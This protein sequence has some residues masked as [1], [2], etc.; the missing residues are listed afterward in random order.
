MIKTKHLAHN[1]LK[2][3]SS[4]T[5]EGF[6]KLDRIDITFNEVKNFSITSS[7]VPLVAEI[8]LGG[9]EIETFPNFYGMMNA[10]KHLTLRYNQNNYISPESFENITNL[11]FLDLAHNQ[12]TEIEISVALHNLSSFDLKNNLMSTMPKVAGHQ[13]K[14]L[15]LNLFSNRLNATAVVGFKANFSISA[16][17]LLELYLGA[18]LDLVNGLSLVIN[19]L[20]ENFPGME[21]L[22]LSHLQLTEIPDTV[23][24]GVEKINLNFKF[25]QI[26][27]LNEEVF[28]ALSVVQ[29]WTLDL[30]YNPINSFSNILPFLKDGGKGE[31]ILGSS[32][33]DCEK[34][35]WM[36]DY[37]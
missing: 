25:N 27:S 14:P 3:I 30:D 5:F 13:A 8:E 10:L 35:C 26:T 37:K 18:N 12:L 7:D 1:D 24:E 6:D 33:F 17:G 2:L 21:Y 19:Y 28:R 23:Y 9:N 31:L 29:E 22:D 32:D 11:E 15:S 34:L 16:G 20:F 36:M 4:R